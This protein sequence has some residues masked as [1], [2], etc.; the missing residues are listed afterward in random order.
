LNKAI[1]I[2][3]PESSGAHILAD[4]IRDAYSFNLEDIQFVRNI[5]IDF[6][7][8]LNKNRDFVIRFSVPHGG[9][10]PFLEHM[11]EKT[12]KAKYML[13]IFVTSRAWF[14]MLMSQAKGHAT[15]GEVWEAIRSTKDAYCFIFSIL[16]R[17]PSVNYYIV[18]Y[19]TLVYEIE[20][21][22]YGINELSK[23]GMNCDQDV[24]L[25]INKSMLPDIKSEIFNANTKW[26][27]EHEDIF[28]L[29]S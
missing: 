19:E 25:K 26:M 1:I 10:T 28:G 8:I 24:E 13:Y 15:S 7:N 4:V 29:S 9:E 27:K 21:L 14:P 18:N 5:P 16:S 11:I 12:L 6:Q 20:V 3:G 23:W 22:L 17:Y 2:I